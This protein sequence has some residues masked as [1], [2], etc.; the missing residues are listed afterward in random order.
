MNYSLSINNDFKQ[1]T[2]D[3]W[4]GFGGAEEGEGGPVIYEGGDT[5]G[6]T[7]VVDRT[8]IGCHLHDP[9][10]LGLD[11]QGAL[12]EVKSFDH[13]SRIIEHLRFPAGKDI[14]ILENIGFHLY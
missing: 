8:C 9:E 5:L 12:M 10:A 7:I 14:E 3:D 6:Y 13:A 4:M 11:C 1:F 2:D